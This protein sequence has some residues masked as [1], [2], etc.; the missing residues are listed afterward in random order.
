MTVVGRPFLQTESSSIQTPTDFDM[1]NTRYYLCYPSAKIGAL[2][3]MMIVFLL[4]IATP[5]WSFDFKRSEPETQSTNV[6]LVPGELVRVTAAPW[7]YR[8]EATLSRIDADTLRLIRSGQAIALPIFSVSRLEYRRRTAN[9]AAHQ[10]VNLGFIGAIGGAGVA[11]VLCENRGVILPQLSGCD[12]A[13]KAGYTWGAIGGLSSALIGAVIG[14]H[15]EFG[16]WEVVPIRA[17]ISSNGI[18]GLR[19]AAWKE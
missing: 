17:S 2:T 3:S 18:R 11:W 6:A 16:I 5:L 7:P 1:G 14:S 13:T 9:E 10:A 8:F 15:H 12:D 4:L 19:V